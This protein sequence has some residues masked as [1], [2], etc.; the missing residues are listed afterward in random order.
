MIT[1][2]LAENATLIV[3]EPGNIKR[4][5]EGR[6]L[7]VGLH[8]VCFTPDM[9]KFVEALGV[10]M[11]IDDVEPGKPIRRKVEI[12]PEQLDAALKTCQHLPEVER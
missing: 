8:L 1:F 4:L 11:K 7:H 5:K 2:P 10:P 12:T 9:Q 3:I 6:P